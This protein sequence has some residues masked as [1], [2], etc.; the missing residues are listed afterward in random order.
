L[1]VLPKERVLFLIGSF[2]SFKVPVYS[3]KNL[4]SAVSQIQC[5]CENPDLEVRSLGNAVLLNLQ[6]KIAPQL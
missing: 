2:D 3:E 1:Y 5:M 4:W 6:P